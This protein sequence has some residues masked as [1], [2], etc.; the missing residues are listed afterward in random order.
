MSALFDADRDEA[1]LPSRGYSEY[2][3]NFVR[4]AHG[5]AARCESAKD[6]ALLSGFILTF[7]DTFLVRTCQHSRAPCSNS[8]R[9]LQYILQVASSEAAVS[10]AV[11]GLCVLHIAAKAATL[12]SRCAAGARAQPDAAADGASVAAHSRHH[13][14][15]PHRPAGP[16]CECRCHSR[17]GAVHRQHARRAVLVPVHAQGLPQRMSRRAEALPARAA[18]RDCNAR[19]SQAPGG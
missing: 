11:L 12:A 10:P 14:Q 13:H 2:V 9:T 18:T 6:F 4:L 7:Q 17:R 8:C 15:S 16:S 1:T 19:L 5:M 3:S